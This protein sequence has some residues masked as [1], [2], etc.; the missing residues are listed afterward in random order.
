MK[1]FLTSLMLFGAALLPAQTVTLAWDASLDASVAGYRI[2]FGTNSGCYLGVTN[3]GLVQTQTVALP[4][5]G[6]WFFAATAM[7]AY[8][9]ESEFSNEVQCSFRPSPPVLHGQ[10]WVRLVPMFSRSTNLVDWSPFAGE[11]TWLTADRAQ[12]F[13]KFDRL[14][15]APA[16]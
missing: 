2:Y 15:I 1:T 8:G 10:S 5:G 7:D 6:R 4:H 14:A 13:F 16:Q 11:P 9:V 3:A 12:E